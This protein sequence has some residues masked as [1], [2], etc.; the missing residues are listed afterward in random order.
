MVTVTYSVVMHYFSTF[1]WIVWFLNH[2]YKSSA[3]TYLLPVADHI[4]GLSIHD[5]SNNRC[6]F[7]NVTEF[8][9]NKGMNNIAYCLLFWINYKGCC[10]QS[11]CKN[12]NIPEITIL[13]DNCSSQNNNYV[14]TRFI[15]IIEEGGFFV[16]ATSHL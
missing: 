2:Y 4:Y 16:T 8:E 13:V 15:K 11:Y 10:Y 1:F 5:A 3:W 6:Y 12:N 9:V 14:M 7:Y